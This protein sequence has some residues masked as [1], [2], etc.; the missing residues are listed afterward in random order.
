MHLQRSRLIENIKSISNY[1]VGNAILTA[2]IL[3]SMLFTAGGFMVKK[4]VREVLNVYSQV[5]CS[6]SLK[7]YSI[8]A[9]TVDAL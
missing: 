4:Y 8:L 3:V 9:A 7:N 1:L 6:K 5:K 2:I